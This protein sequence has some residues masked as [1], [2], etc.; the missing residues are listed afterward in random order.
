MNEYIAFWLAQFI[1]MVIVGGLAI[2]GL[3]CCI[4]FVAWLNKH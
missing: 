1:S 4:Y 2:L 3:I